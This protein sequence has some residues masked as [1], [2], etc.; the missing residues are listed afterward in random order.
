M[1]ASI[2]NRVFGKSDHSLRTSFI[3]ALVRGLK[4]QGRALCR[5][6][7]APTGSS[8]WREYSILFRGGSCLLLAPSGR[9]PHAGSHG[10]AR[11]RRDCAACAYGRFSAVAT[12]WSLLRTLPMRH[13]V[14]W[15]GAAD[16]SGGVGGREAS[17]DLGIGRQ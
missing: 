10:E 7:M 13:L 2:K 15:A 1:L 9:S 11:H 16:V 3:I 14:R 5:L 17:D 8:A 4:Y 12:S 6:G